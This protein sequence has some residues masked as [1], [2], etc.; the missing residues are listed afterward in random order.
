M[1]NPN[2]VEFY[3]VRA[4]FSA[5]DRRLRILTTGD[6]VWLVSQLAADQLI[7]SQLTAGEEWQSKEHGLLTTADL[8]HTVVARWMTSTRSA[9]CVVGSARKYRKY[10][11][12]RCWVRLELKG[13]IKSS[14]TFI[15]RILKFER[16][17]W[18]FS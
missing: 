18:I 17:T 13:Y 7:L 2:A 5:I 10:N 4:L 1:L 8:C 16:I 14:I 15:H 11:F 6:K 9:R 3:D 12:R